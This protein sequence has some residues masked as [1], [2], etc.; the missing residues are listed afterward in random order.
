MKL[1]DR[2]KTTL[3]KHSDHHSKKHMDMMKRLMRNGK[4]FSVAH[5]QAMKK[6]GK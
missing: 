1:T 3:K 6:V 4:T 2:Q 5:K